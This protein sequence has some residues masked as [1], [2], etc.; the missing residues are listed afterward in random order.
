[1]AFDGTVI[2]GI[3]AELKDKLTGARISK[4]QQPEKD[5]L[6][7]TIHGDRNYKLLLS[8][9]AS[10]PLAYLTESGKEAPLQSPAFC[11]LLRKYI[12]SAR[13]LDIYQPN[14]ERII[15]FKLEHLDELLDLK[16]K[17][18][19]IE[20]MGKHSNIIFCDDDMTIMDS[21]KRVPA[22]V[23]SVREVLPGRKYFIAKTVEKADP[24]KIG[25]QEFKEIVLRSPK[26]LF[27]AL[28]MNLTGLS[29]VTASEICHRAGLDPDVSAT[30][31]Y[32]DEDMAT[33]IYRSF[34]RYME[35]IENNDLEPG[36]VFK[37]GEP[38]EFSVIRP[39]SLLGSGKPADPA[40][41]WRSFDSVSQMIETYYAAKEKS[42]RIH[43]RSSDIA[44]LIAN[45]YSRTVKKLEL[46]NKQLESTEKRDK[47]R[48]YGELL[49]TYGYSVEQG[50]K[51]TVINNYYT[52][53][54]MV[55][56]LDPE[57][58]AIENAKAYFARYSKLKRT[59]EAV[60]EQLEATKEELAHLESVKHYLDTAGS[61]DD[62][63]QLRLELYEAGYI[64]SAGGLRSPGQ[65]NK[66]GKGKGTGKALKPWHYVTEDCFHLYVGR[67]NFQNDELTFKFASNSDWW[68]H[69]KGNAGSHV[70]LKAEGREIP[71]RVFEQAGALA[72][73]YSK[74]RDNDKVE[75]DYL[76]KKNVKKPNSAKPGFVVYYTNY[77]MVAVPGT[78][79]LKLVE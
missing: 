31:Y 40:F 29:P 16:N 77:S 27:E 7:L 75:I 21:I 66:G 62:L 15:C 24:C 55:V 4:I 37:N 39:E 57:K 41:T 42:T 70:I 25:E 35:L 47:Y 22:T 56:P 51:S 1:M 79:G 33:H 38:F 45:A 8:A 9:N 67:N 60:T 13:I 36:I 10:L 64:K 54:D 65:K 11:M 43:Q 71:D 73:W 17:V 53:E 2:A 19:I 20:L 52:G 26:P 46:Q 59:Y 32:D 72:A 68:F 12:G 61:E 44:K 14:F 30:I 63:D 6:I 76:E 23:S 58:T 69:V 5:E 74:C 18:L 48:V 34:R 3:V 28:Y 78:E 50:A 49:T